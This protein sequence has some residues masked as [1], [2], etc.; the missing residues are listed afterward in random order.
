MC[1][2]SEKGK[3]E[4]TIWTFHKLRSKLGSSRGTDMSKHTSTTS[5][6]SVYVVVETQEDESASQGREVCRRPFKN[7]EI[8]AEAGCL[9]A[10]DSSFRV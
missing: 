4:H 10:G 7:V 2:F 3:P 5:T 9:D 1:Q 6:G 8:C